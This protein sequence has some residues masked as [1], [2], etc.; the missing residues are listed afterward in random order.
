MMMTTANNLEKYLTKKKQGI[1]L[2]SMFTISAGDFYLAKAA[3][4]SREAPISAVYIDEQLYCLHMLADD[5]SNKFH[6]I[7]LR[8]ASRFIH[9]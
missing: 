6:L 1:I 7:P 8:T 9:F 3:R 2:C 5:W 4:T